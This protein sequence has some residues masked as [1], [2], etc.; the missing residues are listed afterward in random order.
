MLSRFFYN[1]CLTLNEIIDLRWTSNSGEAGLGMPAPW[2][3]SGEAMTF[4][5]IASQLYNLRC[6]HCGSLRR[7][8]TGKSNM[9]IYIYIY[10]I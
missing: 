6:H 4:I 1:I 8:E 7:F 2:V 5:F 3:G 9:Y 10:F